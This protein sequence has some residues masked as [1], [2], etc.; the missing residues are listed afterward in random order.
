MDAKE[1]HELKDNDL[2]EFLQN[3]GD[4]WN[5]HGN[6]ISVVI[7]VVLV[8][9]IGIRFYNNMQ[10]TNHENAWA[11]LASTSSPQGY[12]ERA[13]EDTGFGAIQE[14]ALLRGAEQ[15][16]Q[17]A[18]EHENEDTAVPLPGMLTFEE[19]LKNAEAMY[20]QVLDSKSD[21]VFR[22][23]AAV[24][25]ANVAET[26]GDFDAANTYW[27]QAEKLASDARLGAIAAQAKIRLGMLDELKQPIV[28]GNA[29][30]TAPVTPDD[31]ANEAP[32]SS[33]TD[34]PAEADAPAAPVETAEPAAAP[35]DP[36]Q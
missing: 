9:W 21:P 27:T 36:G 19:S 10:A 2:A 14:I 23:N 4:F 3:F 24:G 18:I 29:A 5:K 26:R 32:D 17:K 13:L 11:D 31:T 20:Q 15:Y 16:H 35:A 8:A 28:F 34:S 33:A 30:Q 25:L 6:S 12:R 7:L 1:R 22:A